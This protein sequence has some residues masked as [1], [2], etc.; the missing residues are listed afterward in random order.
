[1]N[2]PN[3][4]AMTKKELRTYLLAHRDDQDA[5]FAF[6]DKLSAQPGRILHPPLNSIKDMENYPD[7][8][9]KLQND[10]GRQG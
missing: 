4:Q 5:F 10:P 1:M 2:K 7:I 6:A 9:E 8:L 3:F